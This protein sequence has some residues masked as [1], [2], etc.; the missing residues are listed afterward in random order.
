M[1]ALGLSAPPAA[2]DALF[3]TFDWDSTGVIGFRELNKLLRRD[4]KQE[5]RA[6]HL[7]EAVALVDPSELRQKYEAQFREQLLDDETEFFIERARER[8]AHSVVTRSVL[9]APTPKP[10]PP[11]PTRPPSARRRSRVTRWPRQP[12]DSVALDSPVDEKSSLSLH[13]HACDTLVYPGSSGSIRAP[14]SPG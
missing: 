2:I 4:V 14:P 8:R 5:K 3:D 11:L 13:G 6:V 7:E 9:E 1:P 10:L 12:A